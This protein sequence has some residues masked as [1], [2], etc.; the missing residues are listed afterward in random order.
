[1]TP[2]LRVGGFVVSGQLRVDLPPQIVHVPSGMPAQRDKSRTQSTLVPPPHEGR[3]VD[4]QL[5]SR[6][7]RGDEPTSSGHDQHDLIDS[8]G[9]LEG[10]DT[11]TRSHN[12]L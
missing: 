7:S 10:S 11:I 4:T 8:R 5:V 9:S 3:S 2:D 12:Y 1:M 6:L